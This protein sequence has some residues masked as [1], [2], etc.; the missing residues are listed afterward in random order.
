MKT[1]IEMLKERVLFLESTLFRVLYEL[2]RKEGSFFQTN[3]NIIPFNYDY[4]NMKKWID[5]L[6]EEY[7]K[8]VARIGC[9][10]CMEELK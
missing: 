8:N 2:R 10:E 4:Q 6:E 1:E 3:N 7:K 5:Y 9:R